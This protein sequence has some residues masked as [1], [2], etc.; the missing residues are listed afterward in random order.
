MM[1]LQEEAYEYQIL[2]SEVDRGVRQYKLRG[3]M[4]RANYVNRNKRIYPFN[5]L[6]EAIDS[7]QPMIQQRGFLGEINHPAG[8][9]TI[10]LNEVSHYINAM[11]LQEDGTAMGEIIP[12]STTKGE[13]L[14]G[15]MKD[16]IHFGVSTR[17]MGAVKKS[18][19]NEGVVEVQPGLK[20]YAIDIVYEPSAN[21]YPEQII[22]SYTGNNVMLGQTKRFKEVWTDLFG[23]L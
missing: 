3:V 7:V 11:S 20:L 15:L 9:P 10:D 23:N 21:A 5:V 22:E 17:A 6:R 16:K 19:I 13:H 1:I 18:G 12:A 4:A 8:R 14:R 2:E